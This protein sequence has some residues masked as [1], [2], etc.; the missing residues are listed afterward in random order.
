MVWNHGITMESRSICITLDMVK[1]VWQS[2][3][4]PMSSVPVTPIHTTINAFWL[5]LDAEDMAEAARVDEY[6][7]YCASPIVNTDDAIGWWMQETP[8][9]AYPNLSKMAFD[10]LSIS[11]MSAELERLFSSTKITVTDRRNRLEVMYLK[12]YSVYDHGC[13][14]G[15]KKLTYWQDWLA[16][17]ATARGRRRGEV[18]SKK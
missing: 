4:R 12:L 10:Y 9:R 13:I 16:R 1:V 7:Q 6:A 18:T 17:K 5:D 8:R 3:Y 14:S 15:T 11:S 2:R